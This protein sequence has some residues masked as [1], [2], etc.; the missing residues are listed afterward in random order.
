V[1]VQSEINKVARY[2]RDFH[3][4]FGSL[5]KLST[6]LSLSLLSF[7]SLSLSLSLLPSSLFLSFSSISPFSLSLSSLSF[8]SL[9]LFPLS[10]SLSLSLSFFSL[11]LSSLSFLFSSIQVT[12]NEGRS[13][14][15]RDKDTRGKKRL[16]DGWARLCLIW[17]VYHKGRVVRQA[18]KNSLADDYV[19]ALCSLEGRNTIGKRV[20]L[21]ST[22]PF[23]NPVFEKEENGGRGRME[24]EVTTWIRVD[25]TRLISAAAASAERE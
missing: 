14:L 5:D 20:E 4:R 10:L 23:R 3:V 25:G 15:T 24:R 18:Y 9:S 13:E 19:F 8:L 6:S 16:R 2:P 21:F 17:P 22:F 11:S 1:S 12:L 7:F